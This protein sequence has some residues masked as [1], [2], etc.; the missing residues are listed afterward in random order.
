MQAITIAIGKAGVNFFANHYLVDN[1]IK[2]LGGLAPPPRRLQIPDFHIGVGLTQYS[3]IWV[4]LTNGSLR[5]FRPTFQSITQGVTEDAQKTPIFKLTFLAHNLSAYYKWNESFH[6]KDISMFEGEKIERDNDYSRDYD[7]SQSFESLT[8]NVVVQ[9]QYVTAR[10]A[11]EVSVSSSSVRAIGKGV[12]VPSRSILQNQQ[13]ECFN[14]HVNEATSQAVS[15]I[16]FATPI[17]NLIHGILRT[18]PASGDMGGG[19]KYDFS[20]GDSGLHFPN[21]NGIQMGVKGGASYNGAPFPEDKQLKLPLPLPPADSD[22]HHLNMYVSNYEIDALNWAYYKAGKLNLSIEPKDLDKP[23]FLAVKT[24]SGDEPALKPYDSFAMHAEVTQNAAPVSSF[25]VVYIYT[26]AVMAQLKKQLPLDT[27]ELLELLPSNVY[28][29][30]SDLDSFLEGATVEQ[31]YFALIENAGKTM[32]MLVT[33]DIILTMVIQNR[34]D[35]KPYFKFEVKRVDALT[36]LKLGL[37]DNNTQTLQYGYANASSSVKYI[38]SSIPKFD[39]TTF[40]KN[41]WPWTGEQL[42]IANL[43]KLGE[44]GVPLPIMQGFQFVFD[45]AQISTQQGYVSILADVEFISR[46]ALKAVF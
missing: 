24:Y 11:W 21:N 17:N 26:A 27:Y 43:K 18:I 2:L 6:E 14:H 3:N 25:Q 22:S 10:N 12:N 36:D 45:H 46:K 40:E 32:A 30:Q 4:S 34:K 1:L 16:D 15:Q 38:G 8:A 5:D 13:Q 39:G 7:Y 44:K 9:F 19:M 31:K 29:T 42:Y 20:L 23:A 28:L 35:P 41:V 33:Q 37:S